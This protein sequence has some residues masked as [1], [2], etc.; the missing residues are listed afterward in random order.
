M[1][2]STLT[3][4]LLRIIQSLFKPLFF[5]MF[6]SVQHFSSL[7]SYRGFQLFCFYWILHIV[8]QVMVIVLCF[9]VFFYFGGAVQFKVCLII[10]LAW[11]DPGATIGEGL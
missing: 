3:G 8:R 7:V 6:F 2:A 5:L 10:L 1:K 9:V 4:V 11:L